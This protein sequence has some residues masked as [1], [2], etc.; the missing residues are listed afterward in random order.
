MA[1]QIAPMGGKQ[2]IR[3]KIEAPVLFRETSF[4]FMDQ[5]SQLGL[6]LPESIYSCPASST[7]GNALGREDTPSQKPRRRSATTAPPPIPDCPA[8]PQLVQLAA[9]YQ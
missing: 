2:Q 7:R 1:S 6:L 4:F 3:R 5:H 8:P 9:G